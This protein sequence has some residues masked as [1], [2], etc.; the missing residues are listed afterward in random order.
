MWLTQ[1]FAVQ[2]LEMRD[3]GLT[4]LALA[5]VAKGCRQ[6]A[7]LS[8]QG[9]PLRPRRPGG[10]I[11]QPLSA[12]GGITDAGLRTIAAYCT[13]LKGLAITSELQTQLQKDACMKVD[14]HAFCLLLLAFVCFF[15]WYFRPVGVLLIV[16]T[17]HC[18]G[19][20]VCQAG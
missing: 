14:W 18:I 16:E 9:P 11:Q 3:S 10:A 17:A 13:N 2:V 4:D 15:A 8:M 20:Y 12:A 6:L 19:F 1:Q 7:Y 5:A